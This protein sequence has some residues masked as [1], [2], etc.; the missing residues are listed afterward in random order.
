MNNNSNHL[1]FN[2]NLLLSDYAF[3]LA[4][5]SS[6][7]HIIITDQNGFIVY[8]NTSAQKT[9]GFNFHEMKGSTPR[10]WGG[11]MDRDFYKKLWHTIK[12]DR[13]PF[14]GELQNIRKNGVVYT[15]FARISPIL[16][17]GQLLGFIGTEEDISERVALEKSLVEKN[18]LLNE[19]SQKDEA[20]LTSIGE[21][22]VA[23]DEFGSIILMN[24]SAMAMFGYSSDDIVKIT[25]K[26]YVDLVEAEKEDGQK[27]PADGR[28]EDD[29]EKMVSKHGA[30]I[31]KTSLVYYRNNSDN[32]RSRKEKF[33]VG[34]INTPVVF[35]KKI[36]GTVLVFRDIT[37]DR[38]IDKAKTEFISLAS[39]QLRTPI[40]V[41]NWYVE[42]LLAGD[43]GDISDLQREFL[44]EAYANSKKMS[45]L[46]NDLLNVSR[47]E[48]N[49]YMMNQELM[50][51]SEFLKTILTELK[52]LFKNKKIKL[53]V[54]EEKLPK[55]YLDPN[56]IDVVL[57]NL[58]SNSLKYTPEGGKIELCL[59][60]INKND[61]HYKLDSE[62]DALLIKIA[63]N[64]MGIPE[65]DKD[66]IFSKL[67]RGSNV[68]K[69]GFEGTGLGLYLIKSLI[70]KGGGEIWF[71]SSDNKGT[72]FYV[73]LPALQKM[74]THHNA[75]L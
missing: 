55:L 1:S 74:E 73:L 9:T 26:K 16:V 32:D 71:E 40:S 50:N 52:L 28:S 36:V 60:I 25:G 37:S 6:S 66:L 72:I 18:Q 43:A 8:A 22:V 39:H 17:E 41:I 51:V 67:Y 68:K 58:I 31:I 49:K 75:S 65:K 23:L 13:K 44:N 30:D 70:E 27:T 11:L 47:L 46:V 56:L 35:N 29:F 61:S 62:K 69:S 59:K 12:I 20:I 19:K 3:K 57:H 21:G 45:R 14:V 15:A 24:P 34:L 48:S 42:M 38:E 53:T 7:N 63:D 64:G 54:E 33:V 4:T 2:S 10:L 5:E